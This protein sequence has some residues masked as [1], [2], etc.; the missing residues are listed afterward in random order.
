MSTCPA[1]ITFFLILGRFRSTVGNLDTVLAGR[2]VAQEPH[3]TDDKHDTNVT[4]V[5][6][7]TDDTNVTNVTAYTDGTHVTDDTDDTDNKYYT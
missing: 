1:Q 4:S 5:T 7:Y 2:D 6:D 3:P